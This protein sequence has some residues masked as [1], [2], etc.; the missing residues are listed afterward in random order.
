[1]QNHDEMRQANRK[2]RGALSPQQLQAAAEALAHR[3]IELDVYVRSTKL[4]VYFAVNGEIGLDVV[5][6]HA[7]AAGKQV[8]LPNLDQNHCAFHR[9]S[10]N[11]K[12]ASTSFACRNPTSAMSE[13]LQPDQLDLV[14]APLVVFDENRNRIGMGGGFYDR[15]FAMRKAIEVTEPVLIGVAHELQ[16]VDEIIPQEWD[17]RLDSVVTDQAIYV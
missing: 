15:S 8:F 11:R 5:I 1:M 13:M 14:L 9:T 7:L 12:C 16:K 6:D 17:V 3:I 2:R 4:A 10:V